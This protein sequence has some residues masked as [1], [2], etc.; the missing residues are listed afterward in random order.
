MKADEKF[1]GVKNDLAAT[2]VPRLSSA[3]ELIKKSPTILWVPSGFC[4]EKDKKSHGHLP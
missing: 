2:N 4:S 3:E 1:R